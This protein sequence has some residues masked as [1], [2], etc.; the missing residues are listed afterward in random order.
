MLIFGYE[1]TINFIAKNE[2]RLKKKIYIYIWMPD[3][4]II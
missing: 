4:K 1:V 2:I 3:L